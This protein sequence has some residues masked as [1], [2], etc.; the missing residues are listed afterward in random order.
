VVRGGLDDSLQRL[1]LE[2]ILSL[3]HPAHCATITIC[4]TT[5]QSNHSAGIV[6][7]LKEEKNA[8]NSVRFTLFSSKY[9]VNV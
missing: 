2:W 8:K 4:A 3:P 1:G 6:L 5:Q 7:Y 9:K